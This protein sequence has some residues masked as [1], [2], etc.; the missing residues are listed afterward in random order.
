[1]NFARDILPLLIAGGGMAAV[2]KSGLLNSNNPLSEKELSTNNQIWDRLGR[3]ASASPNAM[4]PEMAQPKPANPL[5]GSAPMHP[6]FNNPDM[7][8]AM[9]SNLAGGPMMAQMPMLMPMQQPEATAGLLGAPD[10]KSQAEFLKS[11]L[12][13]MPQPAKPIAV[14]GGS[15]TPQSN[16]FLYASLY[17]NNRQVQ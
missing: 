5:A 3:G 4:G 12:Y 8:R 1:M 7:A 13:G 17:N 14:A 2:A 11:Q 9:P 10:E 15:S 16:P 6:A